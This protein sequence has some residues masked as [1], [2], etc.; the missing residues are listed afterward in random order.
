VFFVKST[1]TDTDTQSASTLA[2]RA[3]TAGNAAAQ[4][5][6]A[7]AQAAGQGVNHGVRAGVISAR[8]WAAPRLDSAADYCTSTVA[9]KVSA[10]LKASAR[11]VSPE[12]P[13]QESR[14]PSALTWALL[15]GAVLAAAGAAAALVRYRY[16][17]AVEAEQ[18]AGIEGAVTGT[19]AA[20]GQDHQAAS[21]TE[22]SANGRVST[23]GW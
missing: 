16:R 17:T 3:R 6:A 19:D 11:Q 13:A 2:M 1:T 18:D 15:A 5:A 23:S 22:T 8:G 14:R 7:A 9:P 20:P 4:H 12:P 21:A 10:A